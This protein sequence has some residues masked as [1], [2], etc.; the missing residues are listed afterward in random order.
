MRQTTFLTVGYASWT[1]LIT[2]LVWLES[3]PRV[4]SSDEH[5]AVTLVTISARVSLLH[6]P[7]VHTFVTHV[8]IGSMIDVSAEPTARDMS[9]E[10]LKQALASEF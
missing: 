3:K 10:G 4:P 2:V 9:E 5:P 8:L 1:M 7:R 6:A